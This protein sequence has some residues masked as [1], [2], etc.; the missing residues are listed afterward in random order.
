MFATTTAATTAL[1]LILGGSIHQRTF[2]P[3]P[4][5]FSDKDRPDNY[6]QDDGGDGESNGENPAQRLLRARIKRTGQLSRV[7]QSGNQAAN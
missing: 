3:I 2:A 1:G 6:S 5:R 4:R 7:R